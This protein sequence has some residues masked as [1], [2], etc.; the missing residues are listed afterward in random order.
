[1]S[2]IGMLRETRERNVAMSDDTTTTQPPPAQSTEPPTQTTQA[3]VAQT[4]QAPV[5]Q[6]TQAPVA[7]TTQAPVAQ[8]TQAPV[9]QTT[10]APV[11]QTTQAPASQTTQ[12]PGTQSTSPN[13]APPAGSTTA[14]PPNQSTVA[15]NPG[16]TTT[17]PPGSS[18]TAAPAG[19]AP[20]ISATI[21][22]DPDDGTAQNPLS[23]QVAESAKLTLSWTGTNAASVRI[24][25]LG[26]NLGASGSKSIGTED[27]TYTLVAVG[28]DGS[29][30]QPFLISVATHP[31][32]SVVAPHTELGSGIA[33]ILSFC[34]MKGGAAVT[35]ASVGDTLTL[36]AHCSAATDAVTIA[37]ASAGL[38]EDADGSKTATT[39]V[40]IAAVSTGDFDCSVSAG[41]TVGDT[42]SVHIEIL[43]APPASTTAAPSQSTTAG[44]AQSTTAAPS[45]STTAA[46]VQSTTAAPVQSTTA[47]PVQS[48]TAAPPQSTTVPQITTEPPAHGEGTGGETGEPADP[49]KLTL[50]AVNEDGEASDDGTVNAGIKTKVTFTW[51]IEGEAEEIELEPASSG[52]DKS[53]AGTFTFTV[54]EKAEDNVTFTLSANGKDG[55][56]VSTTVTVK[57]SGQRSAGTTIKIELFKIEIPFTGEEGL[58]IGHWAKFKVAAEIKVAGVFEVEGSDASNELTVGQHGDLEQALKIKVDIK[59]LHVPGDP[60]FKII[61]GASLEEAK[62]GGEVKFVTGWDLVPT[63][64][65]TLEFSAFKLKKTSDGKDEVE[66]ASVS[67]KAAGQYQYPVQ[68]KD[69]VTLSGTT[70]KLLVEGEVALKGEVSPFY[71]GIGLELAKMLAERFGLEVAATVLEV[72]GIVLAVEIEMAIIVIGVVWNIVSDVRAFNAMDEKVTKANN[73][74]ASYFVQGLFMGQDD[75]GAVGGEEEFVEASKQGMSAGVKQREPMLAKFRQTKKVQE[76]IQNYAG[77]DVDSKVSKGFDEWIQKQSGTENRV[78]GSHLA[79]VKQ[80][81]WTKYVD[82]N[83]SGYYQHAV[84]L[85]GRWFIG[86]DDIASLNVL[87]SP[88]SEESDRVSRDKWLAI[89]AAMRAKFL[90]L[91]NFMDPWGSFKPPTKEEKDQRSEHEK[92]EA[93]VKTHARVVAS[94]SGP[95]TPRYPRAREY[96]YS[97]GEVH[98]TAQEESNIDDVYYDTTDPE[99]NGG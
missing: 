20:G 42:G 25:G 97:E 62:I 23:V 91:G 68:G 99:K 54:P 43:A 51:K 33:A 63:I 32:G 83:G 46:P 9:A 53:T 35:S 44:P 6:T 86:N 55:K 65:G 12:A 87:I 94:L 92:V 79:A 61:G 77:D 70:G 40:T 47:A 14:A 45:N 57:I 49:P 2:P 31:D 18:T 36:T 27:A 88:M 73:A 52:F 72:S 19:G 17:A 81:V 28:A 1:M 76:F 41:G 85:F 22:I 71:E 16:T 48:T 75:G 37:G 7:Q 26:D 38:A 50:S 84:R 96:P 8:T 78:R 66:G 64:T 59:S 10:Q 34:A 69:E 24:A 56:Q 3:P 15:P 74:F 89:P 39:D 5:A 67:L 82:K 95:T 58:R 80:D 93:W 13:N 21:A 98:L 11:A 4:T 29:E 90:P 30:S 60:E